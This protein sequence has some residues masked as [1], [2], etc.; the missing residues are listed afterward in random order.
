MRWLDRLLQRV[1]SSETLPDIEVHI[2]DL[3]D[4]LRHQKNQ[5]LENSQLNEVMLNYVRKVK[6]KRWFLECSLD[7]WENKIQSLHLPHA[8]EMQLIFSETRR[9]LEMLT[10]P[11][12][13][14]VDII[15]KFNDV[16]EQN[17]EQLYA[18]I[19]N[20][21]FSHNFVFLL[22][23]GE[24]RHLTESTMNPLQQGIEELRN[25]RKLVD[26]KIIECGILKLRNLQERALL[27]EEASDD[28]KQLHGALE[29]KKERL[30]QAED[31]IR[32][33]EEVLGEVKN[34]SLYREW[35]R[36]LRSSKV[37]KE[38]LEKKTEEIATFFSALKP[39]LEEFSDKGNGT[40][41]LHEY[42]ANPLEAL[43]KDINLSVIG[44]LHRLKESVQSGELSLDAEKHSILLA[45]LDKALNGYLRAVQEDFF[46]LRTEMKDLENS[47][48]HKDFKE[49]MGEAQ[50][51]IEHFS[52]QVV[53]QKEEVLSLEE[54]ISLKS[55]NRSR[56]IELFQNLVQIAFGKSIE[57]RV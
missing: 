52:K 27:I 38:S 5:L 42:L 15:R 32:K 36:T 21:E 2:N 35:E 53:K 34:S 25:L 7:S 41:L 48:H 30:A 40:M 11:E 56:D 43:M 8:G 1:R 54:D 12:T 45:R 44:I 17:L 28:L 13:V 23:R 16:M 24:K 22:E 3:P 46:K 37:V 51:R 4:W 33:K 49:K 47:P 57:I 14:S 55:T 6:D 50:Y 39:A 29:K 10:F 18:K 26:Q 31:K 9:V 19:E 20:S